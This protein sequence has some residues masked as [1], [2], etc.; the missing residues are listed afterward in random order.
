MVFVF[1]AFFL[2]IW[3]INNMILKYETKW[4]N[5]K[6]ETYLVGWIPWLEL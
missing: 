3:E 6:T 1:R 4:Y 2:R 5:S